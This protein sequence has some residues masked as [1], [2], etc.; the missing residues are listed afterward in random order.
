MIEF[1]GFVAA[2]SL[3]LGGLVLVLGGNT[4]HRLGNP[5]SA[6]IGY[7][8]MMIAGTAFGAMVFAIA[9]QKLLA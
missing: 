8:L 2:A 7:V 6:L 3:I 4:L 1:L 9:M 5:W